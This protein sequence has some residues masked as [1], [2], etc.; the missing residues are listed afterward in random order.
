MGESQVALIVGGLLLCLVLGAVVLAARLRRRVDRSTAL[1]VHGGGRA[2]VSFTDRVVWPVLQRAETIDLAIQPI[3][4]DCR[5]SV[6]LVCRDNIRAD[7][8]L[9][10]YVRV[11]NTVEDVLKV[12]DS[13]GA[14]RATDPRVLNDLFVPRFIEALKSVG[15]HLEF[16]ELCRK[17][18]DF[19]DE[20][21][22]VVG[23]D[24]NGY[25]LDDLAVSHL[26]MTP[27]DALDPTNVF[28]AVGIRKITERTARENVVTNELR[29]KEQ[30]DIARENFFAEE[31][32]ARLEQD[33]AEQRARAGQGIHAPF[34]ARRD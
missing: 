2:E 1:V 21:L 3:E 24:L 17:R 11:N 22:A 14:T 16:E 32:M 23:R 5:R 9:T 7:I 6:G 15:V 33:R 20:V 26:E 31:A 10:F 19:K 8:T 30:L 13:V 4:V 25:V 27:L 28:D 29:Q 18:Q 12:A 34:I